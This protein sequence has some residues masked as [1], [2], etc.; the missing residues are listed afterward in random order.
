MCQKTHTGTVTTQISAISIVIVSIYIIIFGWIFFMLKYLSLRLFPSFSQCKC[1]EFHS[2]RKRLERL[3]PMTWN[4][5]AKSWDQR[6]MWP[7]MNVFYVY[8]WIGQHN[9]VSY[10]HTKSYILLLVT[11]QNGK[12]NKIVSTHV[13]LFFLYILHLTHCHSEPC[14]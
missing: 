3:W 1:C 8:L 9:T 4:V 6:W 7:D 2:H 14:F 11:G 10:V 13:R 12:I 5:W